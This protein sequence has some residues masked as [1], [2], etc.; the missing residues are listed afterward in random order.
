MPRYYFDVYDGALGKDEEGIVL[1]NS[2]AAFA[3]AIRAAKELAAAEEADGEVGSDHRID[4]RDES[5]RTFATVF[6]REAFRIAS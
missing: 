6:F 4:V 1:P 3:E 5:G 2:N